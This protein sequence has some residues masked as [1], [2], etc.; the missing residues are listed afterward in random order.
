MAQSSGLSVVGMDVAMVGVVA[1][2][3]RVRVIRWLSG[4]IR[5]W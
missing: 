5:F 3:L 2:E 4:S 1:D